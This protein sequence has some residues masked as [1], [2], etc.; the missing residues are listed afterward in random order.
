MI[1]SVGLMAMAF[2]QMEDYLARQACHQALMAILTIS[3]SPYSGC[4]MLEEG[5]PNEAIRLFRETLKEH[6]SI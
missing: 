3:E 2:F 6:P 4:T 5:E 1:P